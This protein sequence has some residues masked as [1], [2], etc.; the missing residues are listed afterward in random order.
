MDAIKMKTVIEILKSYYEL[1]MSQ[2]EIAVQQ[3]LSKS[4]VNRIIKKAISDGYIKITVN[5]PIN[6]VQELEEEFIN[7]FGLKK[8]FIAP[9]IVD[10]PDLIKKD[11]CRALAKDLSATIQDNDTIG[12][13][14][15]NT[16]RTLAS[17]MRKTDHK[18][19]KLVQLNGGISRNT[20]STNA[21][22]I[23][24]D[25]S[26]MLNGVG[27]ILPLPT[28]VDDSAFVKV[29]KNDSQIRNVFD[30]IEKSR[31]VL[32]GIGYVSYDSVLYSAKFFTQE[33]YADLIAKGA[34]GDIC[35]R[36]YDINGNIVDEQLDS[37]TISIS[38]DTLKE[39]EFSIGVASGVEKAKALLGALK[40]GY[41]NTLYSDENTARKVLELYYQ[42]IDKGKPAR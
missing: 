6:S 8:A 10:D 29:V 13:S 7:E 15:G 22:E 34:V 40:G 26:D 28:I 9:V 20:K 36:Y 21:M 33:E 30:L 42:Q 35:A 39:K 32:F 19:I 14:W 41:L 2:E 38:R 12:I 16:L 5:Y 24:E 18:G 37:R 4:K 31:I 3:H 17:C 23:I 1:G 25:F 27:Y 11:V